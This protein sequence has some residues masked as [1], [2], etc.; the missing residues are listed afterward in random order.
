MINKEIT[1]ERL[2]IIQKKL[3]N[4]QFELNQSMKNSLIEVLVENKMKNQNKYFG[5]NKYLSSVIFNGD[6]KKIGKLIK[7]K[8]EECNQNSLFGK[9]EKNNMRAA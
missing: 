1:K 9:I 2:I 8:I 5:R 4:N 6:E 7:V 3:F